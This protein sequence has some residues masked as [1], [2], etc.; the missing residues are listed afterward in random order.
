VC[1]Q[2]SHVLNALKFTLAVPGAQIL[3]EGMTHAEVHA[4]MEQLRSQSAAGGEQRVSTTGHATP[5]MQAAA[6]RLSQEAA[7]SS[8]SGDVT[9]SPAVA[10]PAARRLSAEAVATAAMLQEASQ[11]SRLSAAGQRGRSTADEE[12]QEPLDVH[13]AVSLAEAC[14]QVKHLPVESAT[15]G[16]RQQLTEQQI[17]GHLA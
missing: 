9:A 3:S 15:D 1:L 14:A 10:A 7:L 16:T 2:L 13:V 11:L 8:S 4:A 6:R 5:V 12:A 17:P